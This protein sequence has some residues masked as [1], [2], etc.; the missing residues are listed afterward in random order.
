M[1]DKFTI[2]EAIRRRRQERGWSLQ[3]TCDEAGGALYPSF[4]STVEKGGSMPSV[5]IA[6]ALAAALDTT[7]DALLEESANPGGS[8][9][10]AESAKRVPVVPWDMAVEWALNPDPKRLP[11]GTPWILPP[12]N[13]PGALFALVVPDDSMHAMS[14]PAF[15]LG[16]TIFIN[17]RRQAEPNDFVVGYS[18]SPANLTFKRL[19]QNGEQRYLRA[20]NPQFPMEQIDGGFTTVGVVSAMAMAFEKGMI[21]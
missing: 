4:L 19:I 13:P 8:I 10:P 7:V 15:P 2:G 12:E 21:R 16:S 6:A 17:P 11:N 9:A 5:A 18:S 14:G 3:R 1:K 20:L